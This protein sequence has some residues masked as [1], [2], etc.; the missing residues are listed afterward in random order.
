MPRVYV[1]VHVACL[2]MVTGY[3]ADTY[4]AGMGFVGRKLQAV[5]RDLHAPARNALLISSVRYGSCATRFLG[6][7]DQVVEL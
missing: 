4:D 1:H 6:L 5:L 2:A 3:L 7:R